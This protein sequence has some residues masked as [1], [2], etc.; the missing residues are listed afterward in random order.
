M[1]EM[2]ASN[3]AA[4][5]TRVPPATRAQIR[6]WDRRAIEEYGIPGIVLMENAAL[7]CERV[8]LE[9]L[10]A[11]PRCAPPYRIICGP[12]NNGGDGLALARHLH[13]RRLDVSIHL[14]EPRARVRAGSD[15][16]TNLRIAERMALPI[17][18]PGPGLPLERAIAAATGD[19]TLIDALLGTG[20][21]RPLRP[22]YL[23]WVRAVNAA[24]RP[25][26]ALDIPTGLDADTGEVLGEAVRADH[27]ITMAAPKLGFARGEG[28]A[29]TGRIH[30]VGIGA[31]RELLD[32]R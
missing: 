29:R 31:P 23:E 9:I 24:G 32:G 3:D 15:A 11:D 5:A 21:D 16:A 18:E 13:N 19:G 27:T 6:D 10:A 28:P 7:G 8:L 26:I 14:V 1:D 30:L 20:L 17:T 22:P 12:G 2:V 4:S 25:V